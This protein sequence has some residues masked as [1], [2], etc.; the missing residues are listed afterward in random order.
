MKNK[1]FTLVELLAV[2]AILAILVIVAMPNV[3]GMFNQAKVNT[4]T[5]EVQEYMNSATTKFMIE[6]LKAGNNGETLYFGNGQILGSGGGPYTGNLFPKS[7]LIKLDMS[8]TEKNYFIQMDR[9]GKFERVVVYDENFCFDS[10]STN[11]KVITNPDGTEN[12][13]NQLLI[14]FTKEDILPSDILYHSNTDSV[15]LFLTYIEA[16][17]DVNVFVTSCFGALVESE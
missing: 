2:I 6:A 5:T 4:F 12:V 13:I 17:N 14:G 10:W 3:L 11:D 7:R 1:G 9:N 8:G 15:D 16:K